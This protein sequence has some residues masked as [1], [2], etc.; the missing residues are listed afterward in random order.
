MSESERVFSE[1]EVTSLMKRAVELQE[2]NK[3]PQKEYRPGVTRDELVRAA[4][5]IG[6][7]PSFLEQAIREKLQGKT[8]TGSP[9][10]QEEQRVVDGEIDPNDFDLVLQALSPVSS[11]R[12][13]VAQVGRTLS[14]RAMTGSGMA[15]VEVTS[16]GGRTRINVKPFPALE[17]IGTFYPAFIVS[18]IAAA[19]LAESGQPLLGA[20]VAAA[21]FA[22]AA[23]VCRSW[24]GRSR[25]AAARL[26]DRIQ[27]VV[28][29]HLAESAA[30]APRER[31]AQA[32]DTIVEATQREQNE[33]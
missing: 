21:A 8:A 24:L 29:D 7:D 32:T 16:R 6:V 15:K 2:A 26:A 28:A 1:Q 3:H 27:G 22:A 23:L 12:H 13:P 9:L 10:F 11:R 18:M 30:K 31:L 14:A 33:A 5:E 19:P 25:S 20:G 17:I 4:R